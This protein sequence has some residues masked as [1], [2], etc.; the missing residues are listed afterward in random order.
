MAYQ[1]SRTTSCL[2]TT[3]WLLFSSA[4]LHFFCLTR[5]FPLEVSGNLPLTK[6]NSPPKVYS[7]S[8]NGVRPSKMSLPVPHWGRSSLPLILSS[9]RLGR[10]STKSRVRIH[11][12]RT[13]RA[14]SSSGNYYAHPGHLCPRHFLSTLLKSSPW[15][16]LYVPQTKPKRRRS[17]TV[18]WSGESKWKALWPALCA[19]KPGTSCRQR[20]KY[21]GAPK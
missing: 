11:S 10:R 5:N 13:K 15:S 21:P 12:A 17:F 6:N 8:P 14:M 19:L 3:Q 1:S 4:P 18:V 9:C 20:F 2:T 16:T 7:E